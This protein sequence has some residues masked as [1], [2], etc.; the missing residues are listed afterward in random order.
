MFIHS[1]TGLRPSLSTSQI[2]ALRGG[3]EIG[4]K[5]VLAGLADGLGSLQGVLNGQPIEKPDSKQSRAELHGDW[6]IAMARALG[7]TGARGQVVTETI[8]PAVVP[9]RK[10]G[11][12]VVVQPVPVDPGADFGW[13]AAFARLKR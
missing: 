12:T 10:V 5:S 9:D 4:A 13:K 6:N 11:Q 8:P 3:V 2:K 1:L 7:M